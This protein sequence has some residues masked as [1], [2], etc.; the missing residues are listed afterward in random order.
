MALKGGDE[1]AFEVLIDSYAGRMLATAR[2]LT[3]NEEEARDCVQEALILAW[4]NIGQFEERSS[5]ATWLHRIVVNY[6][7]MRLRRRK[8]EREQSLDDLMPEFDRY[9]YLVGPTQMTD[10]D[11]YTLLERKGTREMLCHAIERLPTSYRIIVLLRD[12]EGFSTREVAEMLEI[13]LSLAKTRLHRARMALRKMLAPLW[14][15]GET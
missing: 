8:R 15:R 3:G 7:L 1:T 4:K 9:G 14:Q 11:P 2:R 12:I 6:S 10:D 5:V 13:S